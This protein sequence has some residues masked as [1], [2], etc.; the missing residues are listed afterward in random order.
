MARHSSNS[1]IQSSGVLPKLKFQPSYIA[2]ND[3]RTFQCQVHIFIHSVIWVCLMSGSYPSQTK[4]STD[5]IYCFFFQF[6]LFSHFFDDIKY[7]PVYYV[8]LISCP[9]ILLS[10]TSFS[11]QI[12]ISM[13]PVHLVLLCLLVCRIILFS[14]ILRNTSSF[15]T[16][17]VKLFV[18]I[19]LQHHISEPSRYFRSNFRIGRF[20]AP[21]KTVLQMKHFYNLFL[22]FKF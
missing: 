16:R 14:L 3:T 5:G 13:W 22:K 17:S 15:L 21:Q 18:S 6:I 12:L 9:F 4:F 7:L 2:K 10:I 8:L 20:S 1:C 11:A 19:L